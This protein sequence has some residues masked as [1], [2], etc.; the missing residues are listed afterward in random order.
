FRDEAL[1][2]LPGDVRAADL[3]EN[4]VTFE[5]FVTHLAR[6]Q[7]LERVRWTLEARDVLLHGHC[8]QKAMVGTG[9]SETCL[10]L[11]PN[12]TVRTVDSGCCGMAGAFG[13]EAE[14][15]DVSIAMA[16]RCLAP[17]VREAEE[18]TI[19]AAAGTSCRAQILDT[20]GRHAKHP[21]EILRDALE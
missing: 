6:T 1:S 4:V 17:A 3:A 14:H 18:G 7:A 16:E 13:Y 11:P 15:Y 9:P 12:Y 21:A 19:V 10:G 5:E 2:L 20:T 8:H